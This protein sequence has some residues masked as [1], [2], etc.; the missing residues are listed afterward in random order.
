M[1]GDDW[2][3]GWNLGA[4]INFSPE[5]RLGLHYRSTT[6]FTLGGDVNFSNAPTFPP[7]AVSRPRWRRG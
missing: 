3:W 4:M 1:K 5:T 6:K 2:G 7:P